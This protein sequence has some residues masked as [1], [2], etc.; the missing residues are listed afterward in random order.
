STAIV[1]TATVT[2]SSPDPNSGNNS[3]SVTT[4]GVCPTAAPSIS[5]PSDGQINVG[6]SGTLTWTSTGASSY[7]VYLDVDPNG[8]SKLIATTTS[9]SLPYGCLLPGTT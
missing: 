8:C 9:P 3:A 5:S 7:N 1:N 6:T 4:T 2:S